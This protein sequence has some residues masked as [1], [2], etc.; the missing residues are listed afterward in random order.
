MLLRKN[1]PRKRV[2]L[3]RH[4]ADRVLRILNVSLLESGWM[5]EG[6]RICKIGVLPGSVGFQDMFK[7]CV[8]EHISVCLFP[9][10]GW[11]NMQ[12]SDNSHGGSCHSNSVFLFC[13]DLSCPSVI[14]PSLLFCAL[15]F[16]LVEVY[17]SWLYLHYPA[18]FYSSYTLSK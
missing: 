8:Y 1:N 2:C 14:Q 13:S 10:C 9:V 4:K 16:S 15:Q 17:F 7:S 18:Y 6:R 3:Y 5:T 11:V 12:P